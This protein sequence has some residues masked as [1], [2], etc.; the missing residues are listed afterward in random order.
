MY[1]EQFI[2]GTRGQMILFNG[3]RYTLDEDI[4]WDL[5][6]YR[7]GTDKNVYAPIEPWALL[8][9][10]PGVWREAHWYLCSEAELDEW[11]AAGN[12]SDTRSGIWTFDDD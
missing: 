4:H 11:I 7:D 5:P 9:S 1:T 3:E 8:E 6:T 2:E 10:S 12:W